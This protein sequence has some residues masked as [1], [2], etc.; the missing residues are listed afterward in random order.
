MDI[1]ILTIFILFYFIFLILLFF[2]FIL[3]P[4]K[5]DKEGM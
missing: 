3:F 5:D 4:W 1:W 2:F